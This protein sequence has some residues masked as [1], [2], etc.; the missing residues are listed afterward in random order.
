[1]KRYRQ[2]LTAALLLSTALLITNPAAAVSY[3][4]EFHTDARMQHRSLGPVENAYGYMNIVTD[5]QGHG[6]I[7]VMFSNASLL[8][9][10]LFN[11]RVRFLSAAGELLTEEHFDCWIDAAGYREPIECK[12]TKPL[13]L[14]GFD[15]VE[16]DFY[17]SDVP[18]VTAE[19]TMYQTHAASYLEFPAQ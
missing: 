13:A 7:N 5:D 18:D 9:V 19:V 4:Y 3:P 17:L 16:V 15:T 14:S 11:A 6:V 12:I 1:M 10:A 2:I 8:E